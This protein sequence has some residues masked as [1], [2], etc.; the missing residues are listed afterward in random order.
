MGIVGNYLKRVLAQTSELL[1]LTEVYV[2]LL[3]RPSKYP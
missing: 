1:K 3:L 2:N